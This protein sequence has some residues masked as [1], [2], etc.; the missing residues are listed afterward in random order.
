MS[1]KICL[2]IALVLGHGVASR[3]VL[4]GLVHDRDNSLGHRRIGWIGG[5]VGEGAIVIVD[6]EKD[7]FAFN[8]E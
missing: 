6:L 1:P 7:R 5:M 4:V 2:V 8:L 3:S